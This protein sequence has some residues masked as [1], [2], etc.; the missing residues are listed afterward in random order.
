MKIG[1]MEVE[2]GKKS[3]GYIHS[4]W[5]GDCAEVRIPVMSIA[6]EK[7]GPV[8]WLNAGVHGEE[9]SGIFAI[10]QLYREIDPKDLRGTIIASPGCNPLAI[11]GS[12]KFTVEDQL[13]MDQQ[14]PG[15]PDGWLSQQM[16]YHF[17][18]EVK[19]HANYMIDMH[20]LGGV[21][22]IPYTVFKS[23]PGIDEQINID[24]RNMALGFGAK[25]NCY[26]DLNTATGELPGSVMG[27]LDIQCAI[28]GIPC[29]MAE[30]GAGNRVLWENV[31]LAKKGI[32]NCLKYLN[33]MDGEVVRYTGQKIITKRKF[34][35]V[36][37]GGLAIPTVKAGS[38]VKEGTV[39]AQVTDYFGNV[40]EEMVADADYC[41]IGVL[42]NPIAHSGK[43]VAAVGYEWEEVND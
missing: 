12:N 14:F 11:R 31:E 38:M 41:V 32:Y 8:L 26:V 19:K 1:T 16:A 2:K 27:A 3:T 20:A 18:E 15:T 39:I 34:P 36:H 40:L 30:L 10:Q 9:I 42:E 43:I 23:L 33:M 22:A 5:C 24:A 28:N 7:E 25:F 13:D 21:D 35:C 29:I 6:G 37:K 4:A 17:F